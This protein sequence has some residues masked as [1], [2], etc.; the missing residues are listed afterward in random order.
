M[1]WSERV[2]RARPTLRGRYDERFFRVWEFYL[3]S[4]AGFFHSRQGQL[5]RI[6]PTPRERSI[7]YRSVR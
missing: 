7:G 6:V 4:S 3:L 2:S 1:A 5:W